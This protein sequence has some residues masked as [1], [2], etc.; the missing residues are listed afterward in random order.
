MLIVCVMYV[1]LLGKLPMIVLHLMIAE[2]QPRL[3]DRLTY[4]LMDRQYGDYYA[5]QL[6]WGE[7]IKKEKKS[8]N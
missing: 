4:I 5:L 1:L 2:K 7:H 3:A 6:V 8:V